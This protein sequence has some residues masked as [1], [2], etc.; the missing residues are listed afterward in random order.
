VGRQKAGQNLRQKIRHCGGVGKHPQMPAQA[1]AILLQVAAQQLGLPQHASGV[2]QKS[3]TGR[4]QP[5]AS[6]LAVE[7]AQAALG[8]QRLDAGAGRG[9]RQVLPLRGAGHVAFIGCRHKKPQ[10]GQVKLHHAMLTQTRLSLR[11][12]LSLY[13]KFLRTF[14]NSEAL[15]LNSQIVDFPGFGDD[16]LFLRTTRCA[17]HQET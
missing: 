7:Q 8:F 11:H 16:S 9:Q 5:H 4:R 17:T 3:F 14:G 10:V 2:V 6:G 1:A 12:R 15:V 13:G